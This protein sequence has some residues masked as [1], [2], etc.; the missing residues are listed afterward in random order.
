MDL[1][2]ATKPQVQHVPGVPRTSQDIPGSPMTHILKYG[3]PSSSPRTPII[4]KYH[5]CWLNWTNANP[6]KLCAPS[7][8]PLFL[9]IFRSS[10]LILTSYLGNNLM[11]Q[12]S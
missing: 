1:E 6:F 11:K 10:R 5:E 4:A 8:D 2:G 3:W 12:S 9:P 7:N